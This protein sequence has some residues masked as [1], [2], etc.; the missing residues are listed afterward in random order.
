[1]IKRKGLYLGLGVLLL[2]SLS[3][4]SFG[5]GHYLIT[6][7]R[8]IKPSVVKQLRGTV[9]APGTSGAAGST[10][11]TGAS[12]S[13]GGAGVPGP[14]GPQGVPGARGP[15][16]P[17]TPANTIVVTHPDTTFPNAATSD[18]VT[19]PSGSVVAGGGFSV[20]NV[21]YNAYANQPYGNGWYVAV[22]NRGTQDTLTVFAVCAS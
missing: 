18:S 21:A 15:A 2:F 11:A 17:S 22:A 9:G 3:A 5:A 7:I 10:G 14:P 13:Q 19:C 16:G 1:M 12:G 8:Q 20:S 4:A 6:N